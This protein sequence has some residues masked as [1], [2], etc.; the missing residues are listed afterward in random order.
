MM[1]FTSYFELSLID[2]DVMRYDNYCDMR[3]IDLLFDANALFKYKGMMRSANLSYPTFFCWIVTVCVCVQSLVLQSQQARNRP[4]RFI[5]SILI[6]QPT[7]DLRSTC[8]D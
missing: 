6:P 1:Y 8:L 4:F 5:I 2:R 3:F 7:M